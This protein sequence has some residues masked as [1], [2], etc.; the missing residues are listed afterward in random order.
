[1][2]DRIDFQEFIGGFVVEADELLKLATAALLEI[3]AALKD[4][5]TRPKSVRELFRALHTIKG[6]AGMVGIE[7]IVEIAHGVETIVRAADRS[8]GRLRRDAVDVCLS[9]VR[10]I[11]ERVRAIADG[12]TPEAAPDRLLDA[13]AAADTSHEPAAPAQPVAPGWDQRLSTGEHAHLVEALR[14]SRH[15]WSLVFV[16][17]DEKSA[18]GITITSVRDRLSEVGEIV[19]VVPRALPEGGVAFDLLVIADLDAA[20]VAEVSA[21]SQVEAIVAPAEVIAPPA[22]AVQEPA[23]INRS[24]VRVE[25][26]RLDALQEQLSALIVSRFRLEREIAA[27]HAAGTPVRALRELAELQGRQLRDLRRAI[28]RARLVRVAE[29]LEPLEL[30]VR[31]LNRSSGHDVRLDLDAGTSEL[32]KA[33]ADRLLPAIVHIVRNAVDHAIEPAAERQSLGK[34]PGGTVAVRC[35]E[36]GGNLVELEVEDDG[37]G[38]DRQAIAKRIGREL[39][40]DADLLDVLT[41]PGFSTRDVA[42]RT[43]G[44]GVGMDVV[45]QVVGELGGELLLQSERGVGTRFTLRVPLTIAIVEVFSFECGGQPFVIPISSIEEILEIGDRVEP[46]GQG[47]SLIERRGHALPLVALGSLLALDCGAGARKALIIRRAGELVAFGIDRL[48]GRQE[49][50]VRPIADPLARAPGIAGSADLGDGRPTLVLD[51]GELASTIATRER[52]A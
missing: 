49:V 34:P 35:R 39:R 31:S 52:H 40:D 46:P 3:D 11:A 22:E 19:K 26:E 27:L 37:R 28:L 30:L 33:V 21:A 5:G 42:T 1:M 20:A 29:A 17:S 43:S 47:V 8:G 51:L 2:A 9:A 24:V 23:V 32:D 45:K 36:I 14:S 38:I 6:L 44:R 13:I 25:L 10:A 7:P 41:T 48:L 16:P 50:V 18:R 12:R 15:A 4:G